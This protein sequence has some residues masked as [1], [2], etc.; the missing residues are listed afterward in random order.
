MRYFDNKTKQITE[1]MYGTSNA[2][3]MTEVLL[4]DGEYVNRAVGFDKSQKM[5]QAW[6]KKRHR[7][8]FGMKSANRRSPSKLLR[9][10]ILTDL[11]GAFKKDEK[12][13]TLKVDISFADKFEFLRKV[14]LLESILAKD[15][16]YIDLEEK[17][18]E[19]MLYVED[20]LKG[21]LELKKAV[22]YETAIK[23]ED[24][25]SVLL[26]L[27]GEPYVKDYLMSETILTESDSLIERF[28]E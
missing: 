4:K 27:G 11:K 2:K 8:I 7:F 14:A 20:A 21:L 13:E 24:A 18:V 23:Y 3:E 28:I 16:T 1:L 17:V 22:L 19:S 6:R 10:S 26:A 12:D 25:E 5:K 15:A 9:Q